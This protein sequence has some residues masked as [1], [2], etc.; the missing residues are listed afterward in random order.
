MKLQQLTYVS[1][2]ASS[3]LMGLFCFG[4]KTSET[5]ISWDL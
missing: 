3:D 1:E 4:E 5:N 2:T